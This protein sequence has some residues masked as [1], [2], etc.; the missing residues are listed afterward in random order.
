[1]KKPRELWGVDT[2]SAFRIRVRGG[3]DGQLWLQSTCSATHKLPRMGYFAGGE[4]FSF[5]R[6]D[7]VQLTNTGGDPVRVTL[8]A[9]MLPQEAILVT[10]SRRGGF[11]LRGSQD[12]NT[13]RLADHEVL[14]LRSLAAY[15]PRSHIPIQAGQVNPR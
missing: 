9:E 15:E 8:R 7:I 1:M 6:A 3:R 10:S 14:T 2:L 12:E 11:V 13:L 4:L 5:G